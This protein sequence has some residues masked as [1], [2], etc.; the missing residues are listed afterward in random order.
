MAL[1][2]GVCT[3]APADTVPASTRLNSTTVQ[4]APTTV[5][6]TTVATISTSSPTACPDLLR[7]DGPDTE[8]QDVVLAAWNEGTGEQLWEIP[9]GTRMPSWGVWSDE[10]V[11]GFSDGKLVGVGASSC[12]SW[13]IT[14]AG[15]IDELSVPESGSYIVRS[16]SELSGF[17][18]HGFGS[19]RYQASDT[20][21][22]FVA[23][24]AG[25]SVF[26]DNF[27][28]LLGLDGGG[29]AVFTWGGA[30]GRIAVA[31]SETFLF[32]STGAEVAARP[33]GGGGITWTVEL[34]DI[35]ELYAVPGTLLARGGGQ[36]HGLEPQSGGVRWSIPF[37]EEITGPVVLSHNELHL[38]SL[39]E[40]LGH[41][42]WHLDPL[43]GA[44]I[45]RGEAPQGTEWFAEMDDALLLQ[46]GSDGLVRG[47]NML[48]REMWSLPTGA[49]RIDRFT[50][51]ELARGSVIIT[52]SFSA[53]RF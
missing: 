34:A 45:F 14:I 23:D 10:V 33:V 5:A 42:L 41:T 31:V 40:S 2:V 39:G 53:E 20:G 51:V 8:F 19:F 26:I 38:A 21:W 47:V 3:D 43:D 52:L 11:L 6:P 28:D 16:G 44:A 29:N 13:S 15:G 36:L 49:N 7:D 22:R 18:G 12:D 30:N 46:V 25:V 32:R 1:F 24:N 27:G 4:P 37:E 35:D 48:Q 9:L 17:S 50:Q